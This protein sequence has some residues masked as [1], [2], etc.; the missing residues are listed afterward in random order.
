MYGRLLTLLV[1]FCHPHTMS[2]KQY[3]QPVCINCSSLIINMI[4]YE[5]P[6]LSSLNVSGYVCVQVHVCEHVY[7]G[8]KTTPG[9]TALPFK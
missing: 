4:T 3:F 8:L 7:R 6:E 2:G 9:L 5:F 1:L